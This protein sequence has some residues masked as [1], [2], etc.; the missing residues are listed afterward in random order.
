MALETLEGLDKILGTCV[1]EPGAFI[2]IDHKANS[3][4]F[5]MQN[6]PIKENGLNGCQVDTI[7]E[8]SK[9]ILE[10]LNRK[11]P[12]RENSIA[13][14]KLEETLM[15]LI[16]RAENRENRGVEGYNKD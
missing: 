5:V 12:C 16:K 13:I 9:L 2:E 11:F 3:I 10:G 14:T 4:K 7:I 8:A 1:N 15:W 6:G